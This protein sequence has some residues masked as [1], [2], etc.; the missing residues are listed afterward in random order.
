MGRQMTGTGIWGIDEGGRK[1]KTLVRG[2]DDQCFWWGAG[3]GNR[4]CEYDRERGS[5]RREGLG[6]AEEAGGALV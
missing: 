4:K 3:V 6:L 5:R 1:P 2:R